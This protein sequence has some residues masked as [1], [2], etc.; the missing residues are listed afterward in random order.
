MGV[1]FTRA[2]GRAIRAV[3]AY[4]RTYGQIVAITIKNFMGICEYAGL[5]ER[6]KLGGL[7]KT[8]TLH[9]IFS[10]SYGNSEFSVSPLKFITGR[11]GSPGQPRS[12]GH[13]A[14]DGRWSQNHKKIENFEIF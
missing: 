6:Q 14:G 11:G 2:G 12:G 3:R 10:P 9:K 4:V 5:K 8:A 1:K 7:A 13:G